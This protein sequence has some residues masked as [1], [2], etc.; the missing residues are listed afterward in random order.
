LAVVAALYQVQRDA[1]QG[2]AGATR[3]G[4]R[5]G[6]GGRRIGE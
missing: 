4:E 5:E 2:K 1:R 3:H 6:K